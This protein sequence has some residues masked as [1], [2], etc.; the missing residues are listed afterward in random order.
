[1]W[2]RICFL[3]ITLFKPLTFK[4][5]MLIAGGIILKATFAPRVC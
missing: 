5:S 1:M 2:D 4:V 3:L